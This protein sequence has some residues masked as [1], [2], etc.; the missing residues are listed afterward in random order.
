MSIWSEIEDRCTGEVTRKEDL[1]Q[2]EGNSAFGRY[3][4]AEG[5]GSYASGRCSHS[6][7]CDAEEVSCGADKASC[8]AE[9]RPAVLISELQ[10][11]ETSFAA[12]EF[13][14]I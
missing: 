6:V 11:S 14:I 10:C 12:Y 7:S 3:S 13:C 4:H 5:L 2:Y 1:Q 8:N 9:E